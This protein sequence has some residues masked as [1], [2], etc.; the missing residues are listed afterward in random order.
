MTDPE[1]LAPGQ[2]VERDPETGQFV[3]SRLSSERAREIGAV[4]GKVA[5]KEARRAASE[6]ADALVAVI[7]DPSDAVAQAQAK[8]LW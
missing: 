5:S 7:E 4:G 1:E 3:A 6:L 2:Q 8:K